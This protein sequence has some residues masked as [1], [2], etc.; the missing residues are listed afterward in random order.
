M[1]DNLNL[2]RPRGV[3]LVTFESTHLDLN[4]FNLFLA[5]PVLLAAGPITTF[6]GGG[7][8]DRLL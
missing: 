2:R 5:P 6:L 7:L 8:K 4:E 3:A 1:I